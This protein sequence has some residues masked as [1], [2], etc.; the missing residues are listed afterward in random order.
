[1]SKIAGKHE[2]LLRSSQ[3]LGIASRLLP[4]N[5]GAEYIRLVLE[6]YKPLKTK[7]HLSIYHDSVSVP[8]EEHEFTYTTYLG[9]E[10]AFVFFEQSWPDKN[11]V[12]VIEDGSR[13]GAVLDNCYGLEYFVSNDKMEYFLAVNWYVI[14]GAGSAIEWLKKLQP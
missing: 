6:R 9:C 5:E 1:M 7:G 14:E 8:L 13:L 2:E 3:E 12:V 4:E 10:A 11:M